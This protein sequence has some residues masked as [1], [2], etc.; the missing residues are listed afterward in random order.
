MSYYHVRISPKSAPSKVEVELDLNLQK[1][2]ERFVDPYQTGASIVISGR[3]IASEE[4]ERIQINKTERDS[5]FINTTT[6]EQHRARRVVMGVDHRG[7]LPLGMLADNGEDVTDEFITGPPGSRTESTSQSS[8]QKRPSA[9]T[10]DVFVVHGRNTAAR[11]ALFEFL[12]SLDL[13]PLEWSEAVSA[14]GKASPYI[15]EILDAAFSRAHAVLVLFTPDDEAR[16][17]SEDSFLETKTAT[18]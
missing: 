8:Q 13:H 16:S 15:G 9:G 17:L 18:Q 7:R 6:L 5:V 12:R 11:D 1:L 14:T 2:T 3:A 4:I 10:R